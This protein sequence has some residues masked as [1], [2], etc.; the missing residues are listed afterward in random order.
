M[1]VFCDSCN[2]PYHQYC[3]DP[4]IEKEFVEVETKEWLCAM[5]ERA[6]HSAIKDT[7][8]L[9]AAEGLS[10]EEVRSRMSFLSF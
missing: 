8:G 10:V 1:I 7:E 9:V 6:K 2:T 4:P 3:H 5:C